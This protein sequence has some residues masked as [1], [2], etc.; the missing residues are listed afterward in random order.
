ME[1]VLNHLGR[2]KRFINSL[3]PYFV[4]ILKA[5]ALTIITA[6]AG[7]LIVGIVMGLINTNL[8]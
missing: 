3:V 5:I 8:M 7:S 4:I 2:A 6:G 1:I